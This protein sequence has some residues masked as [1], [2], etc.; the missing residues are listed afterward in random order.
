MSP[1]VVLVLYRWRLLLKFWSPPFAYERSMSPSW[2]PQK[3]WFSFLPSR[4]YL[5]KVCPPQIDTP[6][7]VKNR[8]S[9]NHHFNFT[10]F[11]KN[12]RI[13]ANY[14]PIFKIQN[15]AYSGE[16]PCPV[17]PSNVGFRGHS[18]L[19]GA[20]TELKLTWLPFLA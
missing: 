19:S 11:Q 12:G 20:L 10:C 13:S 2:T 18:R 5:K 8:S 15:L 1:S 16:R 7:L 4:N 6:L 9:Q 14:G 3:F 17:P